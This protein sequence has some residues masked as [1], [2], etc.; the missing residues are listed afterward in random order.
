MQGLKRLLRKTG[1]PQH[2]PVIN[3][4]TCCLERSVERIPWHCRKIQVT[5]ARSSEFC[6]RFSFSS[7]FKTNRQLQHRLTGC[8]GSL[9]HV[10]HKKQK[11]GK[12]FGAREDPKP[13]GVLGFGDHGLRIGVWSAAL[14]PERLTLLSMLRPKICALTLGL[15]HVQHALHK[16]PS[17]S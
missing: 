5:R 9:R 17:R 6:K 12:R 8:L 3:L 11:G 13:K 1:T 2:C 15:L 4:S 14:C 10:L 16:C 7:H